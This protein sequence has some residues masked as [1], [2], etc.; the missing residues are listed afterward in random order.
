[1]CFFLKA[2]RK[3]AVQ[4]LHFLLA[5][6]ARQFAWSFYPGLHHSTSKDSDP[7]AFYKHGKPD[8]LGMGREWGEREHEEK[9]PPWSTLQL[10]LQLSQFYA[11]YED[12]TG[13]YNVIIVSYDTISYNVYYTCIHLCFGYLKFH[14][15]ESLDDFCIIFNSQLSQ[16]D[17]QT[18]DFC[19]WNQ[20]EICLV[21]ENSSLMLFFSLENMMILNVHNV[22]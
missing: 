15:R 7:Q 17:V 10:H 1:M 5:L 20:E 18:A 12:Q 11:T 2:T 4:C 21:Y 16:N 14:M 6:A 22:I 3:P 9:T 8:R 13:K 19:L